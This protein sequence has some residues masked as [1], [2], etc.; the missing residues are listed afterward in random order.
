MSTVKATNAETTRPTRA[1]VVHRNRHRATIAMKKMPRI[2]GHPSR[3]E[4]YSRQQ[5]DHAI[6]S[7]SCTWFAGVPLFSGFET[8]FDSCALQVGLS[9]WNAHSFVIRG[10]LLSLQTYGLGPSG[11]Q[12]VDSL[13]MICG[14]RDRI[15]LGVAVACTFYFTLLSASYFIRIH[16]VATNLCHIWDS[17]S[18]LQFAEYPPNNNY[19]GHWHS[20]VL[21]SKLKAKAC[22][23]QQVIDA[24]PGDLNITL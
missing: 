7:L 9:A 16:R 14:S 23:K 24:D 17:A 10:S 15:L 8:G 18:T 2:A 6:S 3:W 4:Y 12:E 5:M 1:F 22:F 19:L 20:K 13:G 11:P 21:E